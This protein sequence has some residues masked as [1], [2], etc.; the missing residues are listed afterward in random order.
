[1]NSGPLLFLGIFATLAS[2]FWGLVLVPQL[3]IGR[4]EIRL[5]EATG[6]LYPSPRPGLA[7]RGAAAYRAN[8]CAECHSQQVRQTGVDFEIR[9][10]DAGTNQTEVV[11]ALKQ[12]GLSPGNAAEVIT[13][14]PQRILDRVTADRAQS[15]A[16]SLTDLGAKAA[17]VVV[18][19]G[20]DIRRGWG[21]RLS[22]AQD[23]LQD[24]PVLIGSQR[25][26]PDL[27]NIGTRQTNAIWHLL[28]L[29]DP[30][31]TVPGSMM[32]RY[33][34]LFEKRTLDPREARSAD[35][36]PLDDDAGSAYQV[37]PK[38]EA[39]ALVAYLLSLRAEAPLFEAPMPKPPP[40]AQPA[41]A[42]TNAPP[43]AGIEP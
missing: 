1:M 41:P 17:A 21:Q 31:L 37:T 3:Q 20:P 33:Q 10:T 9:L 38:L 4:Q 32:P 35:A 36:L 23:Y 13:R 27:T 34:Y 19:L 26:G 43:P 22:V 24:Y 14:L 29:Y 25:L 30:R 39:H 15:I 7:Q 18:P 12:L 40:S 11:N 28:H 42:T 6:E 16:K 8:G 5:I 2:S